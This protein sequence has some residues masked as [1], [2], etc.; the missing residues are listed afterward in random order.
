MVQ[1]S[2]GAAGSDR[3]KMEPRVEEK[4]SEHESKT[5]MSRMNEKVVEVTGD[6]GEMAKVTVGTGEVMGENK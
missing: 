4:Q 3:V 5:E 6:L 1:C 2:G